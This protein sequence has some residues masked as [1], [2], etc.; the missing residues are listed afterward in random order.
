MNSCTGQQPAQ[1]GVYSRTSG[2]RLVGQVND[3]YMSADCIDVFFSV[4]FPTRLLPT[5]YMHKKACLAE[6][7]EAREK[8]V[9]KRPVDAVTYHTTCLRV[10]VMEKE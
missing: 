10:I 8:K 5:T 3:L 2:K 9:H 1:I 7:R 6:E 4:V